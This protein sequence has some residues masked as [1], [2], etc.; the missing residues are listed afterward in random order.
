MMAR[1]LVWIVALAA[2]GQPAAKPASVIANQRPPA[3]D[4]N[5]ALFKDLPGG[6][7]ALVGGNLVKLE[8]V[9]RSYSAKYLQSALHAAGIEKSFKSYT[10]CLAVFANRPAATAFAAHD[11]KLEMRSAISGVGIQD[12]AACATRA[13]FAARIDADGKY[14][15]TEIIAGAKT[16]KLGMLELADHALYS[17]YSMANGADKISASRAELEADAAVATRKSAAEDADLLDIA[18]GVDRGRMIW[19]AGTGRTTSLADL[20]GEFSGTFDLE[21]GLH[22]DVTIQVVNARTRQE[23]LDF[24]AATKR[25]AVKVTA[26]QRALLEG[27]QVR[28]DGDRVHVLV[29]WSDAQVAAAFATEQR[30]KADLTAALAKMTEFTTKMCTCRDGACAQAVTDEMT[31]WGA[32]MAKDPRY[33]VAQISDDD[34]KRMADITKR[35]TDCMTAAMAASGSGSP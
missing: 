5:S 34:A 17:R 26:E 14:V 11:H 1:R 30:P 2:C 23:L 18:R 22:A 27:I 12:I 31:K 4:R 29:T 19:I 35:M 28:S 8:G 16:M 10:D 20:L 9:L 7:F 32:Q 25:D 13:G 33:D 24:F 21:S 6:N 15:E 3:V